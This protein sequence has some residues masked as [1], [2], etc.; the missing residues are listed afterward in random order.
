MKEPCTTAL[1]LD[2]PQ[3]LLGGINIKREISYLTLYN[4]ECEETRWSLA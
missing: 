2:P 4:G 3:V 1:A